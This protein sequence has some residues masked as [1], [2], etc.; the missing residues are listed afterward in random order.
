MDLAGSWGQGALAPIRP[1]QPAVRAVV[2]G[3]S[4][5]V[6]LNVST[7]ARAFRRVLP[8]RSWARSCDS[9]A[10]SIVV[11]LRAALIVPFKL[12][13]GYKPYS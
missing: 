6:M 13:Y 7:A 8:E 11:R 4:L 10:G 2:N 12:I 9:L 5:S 1:F 3:H